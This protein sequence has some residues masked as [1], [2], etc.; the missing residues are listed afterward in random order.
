MVM[1]SGW[2]QSLIKIIIWVALEILLTVLGVD[3]LADYSEFIFEKHL[4][5]ISC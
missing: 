4:I 1:K 2:R 5:T 3:D